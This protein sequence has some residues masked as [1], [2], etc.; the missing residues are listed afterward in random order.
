MQIMNVIF[1]Y[2]L[3]NMRLNVHGYCFECQIRGNF[4]NVDKISFLNSHFSQ[5][6]LDTVFM[7]HIEIFG[8]TFFTFHTWCNF[9]YIFDVVFYYFD[10]P[11]LPCS[12]VFF[13]LPPSYSDIKDSSSLSFYCLRFSRF[14][15]H[16]II[17]RLS[18][19]SFMVIALLRN[20]SVQL[21]SI[22]LMQFDKPL[23]RCS[24]GGPIVPNDIH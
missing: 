15:N 5:F 16:I 24:A 11:L 8:S 14:V 23:G 18:F 19:V 2:F 4:C 9:N 12:L 20:F 10:F 21:L 7:S 17:R 1:Y 22:Y 13:L 6:F 3:S